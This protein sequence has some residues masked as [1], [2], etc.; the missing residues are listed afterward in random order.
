MSSGCLQENEVQAFLEGALP[1]ARVDGVESHLDVCLKCQLLVSA[2]VRTAS[3]RTHGLE[4][5]AAAR[6]H[7]E[8]GDVVSGRYEITRFI[9]RGGM[10]EVYAAHDR[11]LGD[12]IALKVLLRP[13]SAGAGA[14]DRLRVEVQ[15]ARRVAD[16]HV[17]RVFDLGSTQGS[18][19]GEEVLFLTMQ[20]LRGETLRARIRRAGPLTTTETWR[21]AG[22]MF[23]ALA[24][25]HQIG[26]VHRDFKSDNVML[27][28][29]AGDGPPR[30]I[31]MDFGLAQVAATDAPSTG[32]ATPLVAGTLGYMAPEQ[33]AGGVVTAAVDVYAFGV[34]LHEML[35][36]VLP[37]FRPAIARKTPLP[38]PPPPSTLF[39]KLD[40]PSRWSALIRRCLERDPAARFKNILE[41]RDA[42]MSRRGSSRRVVFFGA[43]A[44]TAALAAVGAGLWKRAAIPEI[45]PVATT[46]P[47]PAP[48]AP[49]SPLVPPPATPVAHQAIEPA[50]PLPLPAV[51][52]PPLLPK[53]D[54]AARALAKAPRPRAAT[55]VEPKA[56]APR[57]APAPAAPSTPPPRRSVADTDEA[58]DPFRESR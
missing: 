16:P 35:T 56:D 4:G 14:L 40:I 11:M 42:V 18:D 9:A 19:G 10:G 50:R 13:A 57:P 51:T 52:N 54:R 17:L 5:E 30:A 55:H 53:P 31:V 44:A 24:A 25:A 37:P 47:T 8:V 58:I 1:T 36:G 27:V 6:L 39:E 33:L 43:V 3:L 29:T 49:P 45:A 28:P 26:I 48:P 32:G 38:A 21:L 34:V 41:A 7:F 23:A 2:G 46:V 20:L 15:L 22:D 12:E